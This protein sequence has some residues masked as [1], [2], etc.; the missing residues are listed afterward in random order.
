M[1]AEQNI[2][3][4]DAGY[5]ECSRESMTELLVSRAFRVHIELS[6]P[7]PWCLLLCWM[8]QLGA[9]KQRPVSDGIV[10]SSS[11]GQVVNQVGKAKLEIG[12]GMRTGLF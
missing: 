2:A 8:C 7:E 11:K 10:L 9:A 12:I 6:S 1:S 4:A 5:S 3:A